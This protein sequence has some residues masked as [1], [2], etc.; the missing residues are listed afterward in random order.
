MRVEEP[1]GPGFDRGSAGRSLEVGIGVA[2]RPGDGR[3]SWVLS[4]GS[5]HHDHEANGGD[6]EPELLLEVELLSARERDRVGDE[7]EPETDEEDADVNDRPV[8]ST[9]RWAP[10]TPGVEDG[11]PST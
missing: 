8:H 10:P 5:E 7:G 1:S 11:R 9:R 2:E 4:E 6:E 3:T